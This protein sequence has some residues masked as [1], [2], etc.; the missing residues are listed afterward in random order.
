M[1]G[2]LTETGCGIWENDD[3]AL[4]TLASEV[5]IWLVAANEPLSMDQLR[6]AVS[7]K[8]EQRKWDQ[9]NFQIQN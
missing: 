9:D 3:T 2:A 1:H 6:E 8:Q 7:I 4:T 5:C